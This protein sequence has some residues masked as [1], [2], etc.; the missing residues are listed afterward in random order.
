MGEA[1]A[2]GEAKETDLDGYPQDLLKAAIHQS[3]PYNPA[4]VRARNL[5]LGIEQ[6]HLVFRV[7]REP[8]SE[9]YRVRSST[10]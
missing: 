9:E 8:A 5:L 3:W 1:T 4:E 10:R 7:F 6:H 2:A